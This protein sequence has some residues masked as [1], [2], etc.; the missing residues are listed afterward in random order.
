[1][2]VTVRLD[3]GVFM[4][5]CFSCLLCCIVLLSSCTIA[6]LGNANK[7][8]ITQEL[9]S[10][11]IREFQYVDSVII[12]WVEDRKLEI[13]LFPYP[14]NKQ[15]MRDI[16]Y[17][18]ISEVDRR[19]SG[20][21]APGKPRPYSS[22]SLPYKYINGNR[23]FEAYSIAFWSAAKNNRVQSCVLYSKSKEA[24]LRVLLDRL[25]MR[26]VTHGHCDVESVKYRWDIDIAGPV[27]EVSRKNK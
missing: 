22:M 7:A 3:L 16:V 4:L 15:D 6:G 24:P 19:R 25:G 1:V 17:G 26:V 12:D 11:G 13:Y 9:K 2:A 23:H 27:F 20:P 18:R 21:M 14:L 5:R 8:L 10:D